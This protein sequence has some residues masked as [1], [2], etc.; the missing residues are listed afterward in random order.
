MKS[1]MLKKEVFMSFFL[2]VRS[3][4]LIGMFDGVFVKYVVFF[5][6]VKYVLMFIF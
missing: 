5:C 2:N 3:L 6:E 1:K 4:I